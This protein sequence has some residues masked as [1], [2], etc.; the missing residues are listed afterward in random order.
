MAYTRSNSKWSTLVKSAN[1]RRKT[2][3][4][5]RSG[6]V[7]NISECASS[8][9][10]VEIKLFLHASGTSIHIQWE[11]Q[12]YQAH[13]S[14]QMAERMSGWL[15][16]GTPKFRIVYARAPTRAD[17]GTDMANLT[18]KLLQFSLRTCHEHKVRE[19]DMFPSSGYRMR[20]I[21]RTS[22][23]LPED[24]SRISFWSLWFMYK[25]QA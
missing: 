16:K 20:D 24:G 6:W 12:T 8:L 23:I 25:I 3:V 19:S 18:G 13:T 10:S 9:R 5:S 11:I 1:A 4:M 22:P 21:P 14:H 2:T 15:C 7:L 17:W